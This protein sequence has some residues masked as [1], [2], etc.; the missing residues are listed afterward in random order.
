MALLDSSFYFTHNYHWSFFVLIEPD[1]HAADTEEVALTVP[2]SHENAQ[3]NLFLYEVCLITYFWY[4]SHISLTFIKDTCFN[5][6][7][8]SE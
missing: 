2:D 5:F 7:F 1:G 8:L 6:T 4:E 3:H